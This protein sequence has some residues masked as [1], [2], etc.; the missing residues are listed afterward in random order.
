MYKTYNDYIELY[1]KYDKECSYWLSLKD[2]PQNF[3]SYKSSS[4]KSDEMLKKAVDS[5]LH[6]ISNSNTTYSHFL[7]K[8]IKSIINGHSPLAKVFY[9]INLI[10]E[11][12]NKE[13]VSEVQLMIAWLIDLEYT[14]LVDYYL[15]CFI[16]IWNHDFDT[17][18]PLNYLEHIILSESNT[19][20]PF[21]G[22]FIKAI[23]YLSDYPKE[24]EETV[25]SKLKVTRKYIEDE[26]IREWVDG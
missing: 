25:I 14:R 3:Q 19:K 10:W 8:E 24:T 18:V 4:D 6:F 12:P 7:K 17:V 5:S 13:I 23:S 16:D 22:G 21:Y 2:T 11:R 15:E 9:L 20:E 1:L 26:Y